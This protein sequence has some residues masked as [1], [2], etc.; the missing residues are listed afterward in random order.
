MSEHTPGPWTVRPFV[1][2]KGRPQGFNVVSEHTQWSDVKKDGT[3]YKR[4]K[5]VNIPVARGFLWGAVSREPDAC[6]IAAAPKLLAACKAMLCAMSTDDH[7]QATW[8]IMKAVQEAEGGQR[9]KGVD[10]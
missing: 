6:L 7:R 10:Q 2:S 3:P 4:A 5:L 8:M 9:A 1:H